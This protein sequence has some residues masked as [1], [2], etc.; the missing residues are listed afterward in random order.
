MKVYFLFQRDWI[1]LLQWNCISLFQWAWTSTYQRPLK[2]GQ[3]GSFLE[4]SLISAEWQSEMRKLRWNVRRDIWSKEDISLSFNS[5][6][7]NMYFWACFDNIYW[8]GISSMRSWSQFWINPFY[9]LLSRLSIC[10][11]EFL[12]VIKLKQDFNLVCVHL[13]FTILGHTKQ[14]WIQTEITIHIL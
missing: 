5:H 13:L 1:S 2:S 11:P 10:S 6:F 4:A 8:L 12:L 7:Q 14:I 3:V 9:P